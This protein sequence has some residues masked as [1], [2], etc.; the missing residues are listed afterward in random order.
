MALHPDF[1]RTPYAVAKLEHRWTP[2]EEDRRSTAYEKLL[3]PLQPHTPEQPCGIVCKTMLDG[4]LRL[5]GG[6]E[7][8]APISFAAPV[9]GFT[10]YQSE[11]EN[12]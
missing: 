4:E 8:Y 12:A 7:R 10:E 1:P 11:P 6:F 2:A 5:V 3:P 9:S